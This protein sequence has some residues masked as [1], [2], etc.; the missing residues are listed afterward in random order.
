MSWSPV[1]VASEVRENSGM[2]GI[3]DGYLWVCAVL[4]G[5]FTRVAHESA[6]AS[7]AVPDLVGSG[8]RYHLVS[9]PGLQKGPTEAEAWSSGRPE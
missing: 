5:S 7:A 8:F 6:T 9:L 2:V 1:H 4:I 3:L